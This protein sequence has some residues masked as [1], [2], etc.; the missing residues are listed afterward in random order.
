MTGSQGRMSQERS[1]GRAV[2]ALALL[3]FGLRLFDLGR[4][5]LW[6]DEAATWWFGLQVIGGGLGE[7][8]RVEPTPP[9]HYAL[10]GAM[11]R[12][13]GD[14]DLVL[15]LPSAVFA[16]LG[17]WAVFALTRELV[18][19]RAGAWAA[20]WLAIHP[21]HVS[22]GREARVYTLL[23]LLAVLLWLAL[24]RALEGDRLRHWL[25]VAGLLALACWSHFYG[26]FLGFTVGVLVLALAP[27]WR[28][29]GR[30]LSA[31]ALGG[32]LFAPYL[33]LAL[34]HLEQ[35]GADWSVARL[36]E[37]YPEVVEPHW[38]AE[39]QAIGARRHPTVRR[40]ATP[41]T[42]A[43]LWAPAMAVQAS[44]VV[45]AFFALGRTRGQPARGAAPFATPWRRRF[46]AA[47][48][49]LVPVAV[50]WAISVAHRPIFHPGRHDFYVLGAS[51][52][53]VGAG[54]DW[55]GRKRDGAARIGPVSPW[56]V[57]TVV[58]LV[59]AASFRLAWLHV[60]PASDDA[61]RTGA[62]LAELHRGPDSPPK[63]V[64]TGIRRLVHERYLSQALGS[65]SSDGR[66]GIES[67][68]AST[69]LHP[70][71]ADPRE[72]VPRQDELAAEARSR[73]RQWVESEP[74]V[75]KVVVL[76]RPYPSGEDRRRS[77]AWWVDRH[78]FAA[79]AEAG[80][81]TGAVPGAG[82]GLAAPLPGKNV[83]VFELGDAAAGPGLGE[84]R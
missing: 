81:G 32:L 24:W 57:S 61:R 7:Q 23:L 30:G 6:E 22:F 15:R 29:R 19:A 84:G 63:V 60:L 4:Q 41:S 65:P 82:S 34:P 18:S 33:V 66:A 76:A 62:W 44:L 20:G 56:Q 39:G 48:I 5:A 27:S 36:Y 9:L 73:V 72:L 79:L 58:V 43:L 31:A 78:L 8:L 35:T 40:L 80:Y 42:P 38:I 70:G 51:A 52:L 45:L 67:F 16:A 25:A 47:S 68:P 55:L 14:S 28:V 49:W 74:P 11:L 12:L 3:A 53:L 71:W 17:V 64:A 75:S 50:P 83:R 13:F 21:W 37:L 1:S 10:S 46:F 2:V 77:E 69:D 26:L 59:L 54:V